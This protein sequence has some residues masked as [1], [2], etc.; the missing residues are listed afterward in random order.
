V[1]TALEVTKNSLNEI[2]FGG[3]NRGN[4]EIDF[5]VIRPNHV[6]L[7]EGAVPETNNVWA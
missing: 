2:T 5:S 7:V 4:G 6:G 1:Q 3:L